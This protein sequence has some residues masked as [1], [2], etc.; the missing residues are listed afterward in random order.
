M[1]FCDAIPQKITTQIRTKIEMRTGRY[2]FMK[3]SNIRCLLKVHEFRSESLGHKIYLVSA[4][5]YES[6][7][8]INRKHVLISNVSNY[9]KNPKIVI[10]HCDIFFASIL[11]ETKNVIL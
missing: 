8:F 3:S 5:N 9:I 1:V 10:V 4:S 2:V 6:I 11:F 7:F